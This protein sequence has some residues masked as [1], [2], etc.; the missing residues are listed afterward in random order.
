MSEL[1]KIE[2][3]LRQL[4]LKVPHLMAALMDAEGAEREELNEIRLDIER[5]IIALRARKAELKK[6]SSEEKIQRLHSSEGIRGRM[7]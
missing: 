5:Q 1:I 2:T 7:S 6:K 3:R 4:A